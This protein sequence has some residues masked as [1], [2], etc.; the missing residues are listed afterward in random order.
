ML[1]PFDEA[2]LKR[3]ANEWSEVAARP[4]HRFGLL[5]GET[6]EERTEQI[7][8]GEEIEIAGNA[9]MVGDVGRD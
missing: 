7:E 3:E 5:N 4:P 2:L 8:R 1:C 6:D 9:E